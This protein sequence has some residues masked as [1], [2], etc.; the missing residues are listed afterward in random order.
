MWL[1]KERRRADR[2]DGE[3]RVIEGLEGRQLMAVAPVIG[4]P[5]RSRRRRAARRG[6]P[7]ART[8]ISGSSRARPTRSPSRRP[9]A[10]IVEYSLPTAGRQ[11]EVDRLG[12]GGRPLVHGRRGREQDRQERHERGT[13]RSTRSRAL[14]SSPAGITVGP[15][16]NIWF[17]EFS[18]DKVGKITPQGIVTEYDAPDGRGRAVEHHAGGDGNL[19][20]TENK[21]DQIGKISPST[22]TIAEYPATTSSPPTSITLGPD[23]VLW[24]TQDQTAAIGRIGDF[25]GRHLPSPS[26]PGGA[27]GPGS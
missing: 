9:G 6:S 22:G 17:T 11:P 13:S 16:G 7:S 19:W 3:G 21:A 18:G 24:F 10:R 12:P 27:A 14:G 2:T 5:S 4:W 1:G 15:D 20:F 26:L 8:E 23:G 25:G